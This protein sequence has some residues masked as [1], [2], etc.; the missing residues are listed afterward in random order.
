MDA[1]KYLPPFTRGQRGDT[2]ADQRDDQDGTTGS[3]LDGRSGGRRLVD[4]GGEHEATYADFLG[5]QVDD[6]QQSTDPSS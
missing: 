1:S 3:G 2:T 6:R 4:A 5:D